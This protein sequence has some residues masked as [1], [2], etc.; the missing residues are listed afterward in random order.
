MPEIIKEMKEFAAFRGMK[1]VIGAQTN[2][3]VDENYLRQFDFI[4]GGVGLASNGTVEN[5]AC[6]SRWDNWC[7]ALLWHDNYKSKANNVF[8][9]LDWSGRRGDDMSTFA[10]MAEKQR[11]QTL[12]KLHEHFTSQDV[13]FL[14]PIQ[15][16]LPPDNGG[17]HG[18]SKKYYTPDEKYSCKDEDAIKDILKNKKKR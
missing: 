10:L 16:V 9:H 12:I 5:G 11:Q 7:W 15:A 14:L 18:P 3:I 4:E 1:I 8:V 6:F 2:D 17:C 13:G